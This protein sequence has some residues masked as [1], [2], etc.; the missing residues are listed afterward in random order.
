M[1]PQR[2]PR[3]A[4]AVAVVGALAVPSAAL[5]A[6]SGYDQYVPFTPNASGPTA[7]GGHAGHHGK[8][9]SVPLSP[10]SSNTLRRVDPG[11]ATVLRQIAT[12]S[13]LGATAPLSGAS[14]KS[15]KPGSKAGAHSNTSSAQPAAPAAP[16]GISTT[17]SAFDGATHAI[18]TSP[19]LPL[20]VVAALGTAIL[21]AGARRR[22]A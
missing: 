20:L 3:R 11:T 14:G 13:D 2:L 10:G 17:P 9:P 22:R 21:V 19:V 8:P 5:G 6:T 4:L 1:A 12:S 7:P 15:G 16:R 18:G